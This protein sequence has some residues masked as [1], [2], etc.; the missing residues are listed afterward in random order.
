[1]EKSERTGK[2]RE[3]KGRV[4]STRKQTLNALNAE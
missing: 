3:R 1:M 2:I 4:G